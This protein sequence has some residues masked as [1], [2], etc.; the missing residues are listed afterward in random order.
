[1]KEHLRQILA[2]SAE[3]KHLVSKYKNISQFC[4]LL[5]MAVAVSFFYFS[6]LMY[7][8]LS[9]VDFDAPLRS[10]EYWQVD[11][12]VMFCFLLIGIIFGWFLVLRLVGLILVKFRL[13]ASF[14]YEDFRRYGR[15][16]SRCL[17]RS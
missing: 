6:S 15:F 7:G 16:P 14:E 1:M 2:A 9:G 11:I 13:L 17:K 8:R 4:A 5:I 12:F 3:Q 10:Q